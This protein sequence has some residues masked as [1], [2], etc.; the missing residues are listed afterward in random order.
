MKLNARAVP[1]KIDY[2]P[3]G[4]QQ[5]LYEMEFGIRANIGNLFV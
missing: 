4:Q 3:Q 1:A 2:K 5:K